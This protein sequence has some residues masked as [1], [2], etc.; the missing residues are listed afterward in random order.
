MSPA[1]AL[2]ARIEPVSFTGFAGDFSRFAETL[3]ASFARYGFAV[4]SE[5]DLPQARIDAAQE[6][7][8]GAEPH[9]VAL[10]QAWRAL[11]LARDARD[12]LALELPERRVVL[13]VT[14]EEA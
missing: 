10:W 13:D 5:H 11:A 7:Q 6:N 9:L 1:H 14:P 12:P 3:G 8:G 4:I 2:P